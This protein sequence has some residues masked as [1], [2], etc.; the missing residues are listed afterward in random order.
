[1]S[2][3]GDVE[4]QLVTTCITWDCEAKVHPPA[5][6]CPAHAAEQQGSPGVIEPQAEARARA[7][8]DRALRE[9]RAEQALILDIGERPMPMPAE[10]RTHYEHELGRQIA[11]SPIFPHQPADPAKQAAKLVRRALKGRYGH[12]LQQLAWALVQ[13]LETTEDPPHPR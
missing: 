1:M 6:F 8:G 9:A 13:T 2:E 10:A 7:A 12:S 3:T 11:P 4:R 5:I